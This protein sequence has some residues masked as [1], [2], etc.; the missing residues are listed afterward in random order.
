MVTELKIQAV[1]VKKDNSYR[2]ILG[3]DGGQYEDGCLLVCCA[4]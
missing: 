2:E 4:V 3:S 1:Q